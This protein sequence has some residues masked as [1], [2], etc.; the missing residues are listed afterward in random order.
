MSDAQPDAI[1]LM[2]AGDLEGPFGAAE[3]RALA[4]QI[5]HDLQEEEVR[6][7]RTFARA[8]GAGLD[9]A[10]LGARLTARA[11]AETRTFAGYALDRDASDDA[12]A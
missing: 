1:P 11:A 4:E 12:S 10:A 6:G 3:V 7:G 2:K 5:E 8:C 9:M